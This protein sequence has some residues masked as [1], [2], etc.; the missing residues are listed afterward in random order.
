MSRLIKQKDMTFVKKSWGW[1]KWI[2]N[3][4]LYCGKILFIE[5]DKFCSFHSHILKDEVLYL[6]SGKMLFNYAEGESEGIKQIEMNNGD[7]YHIQPGLIHQMVALEDCTI[8]ETSTQ[9]F[10]SDSYRVT[11]KKVEPNENVSDYMRG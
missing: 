1:E 2:C 3:S 5:K 7:A 10:D 4:N 8:I 11:K 9:H 6:S